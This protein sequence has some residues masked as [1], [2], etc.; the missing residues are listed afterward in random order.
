VKIGLG[1]VQFGLNYGL[2]NSGGKTPRV[3]V[4]RILGEALLAGIRFIDSASLYGDSEEILGQSWPSGHNFKVV[5]KTPRLLDSA[6]TNLLEK[7]LLRSLELMKLDSVYGLLVHNADDLLLPD[8]HAIISALTRLREQGVITKIG[9]SVYNARQIDSILELFTPDLIQL[10]VNVFDQS[11][12]LSGHL[13][14]LKAAGVEIHARSAFLQGLLLMNPETLPAHFDSVKFK[15]Q[16][17]HA[18]LSLQGVTPVQAALGFVAGLDE[19]DT[20]ICGVNNL[21]QLKELLTATSPL[22]IMDFYQFAVSDELILNPSKWQVG[23]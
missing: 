12:L 23:A 14:M 17:Y 21:N 16:K 6:S 9:V 1:T 4:C 15:L 20:I 19:I 22:P 3:E 13:S 8:G 11:L 2:S 5:T 18:Y 10:P 7:T